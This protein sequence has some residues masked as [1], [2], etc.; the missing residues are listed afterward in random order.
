MPEGT[1]GNAVINAT[2]STATASLQAL[3][4]DI[5][6]R[7]DDFLDEDVQSDILKAVQAQ[8]RE[9]IDV[10]GDALKRYTYVN[11]RAGLMDPQYHPESCL[12]RPADSTAVSKK[13]PS[14]TT[15]AKTA[16]SC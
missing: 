2:T 3:C 6:R 13:Y 16:S 10:I 9:A 11:I 8:T 12:I 7:V 14:L 15:V 4:A 5:A 1:Y